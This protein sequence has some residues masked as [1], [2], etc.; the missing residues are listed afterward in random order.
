[1]RILI[2]G[3]TGFIGRYLLPLMNQHHIMLIGR[4]GNSPGG[5][6]LKFLK[7]DLAI[8]ASWVEQ[9]R[10]FSPE[11]CIHLAWSGLPDYS[12]AKCIENFNINME[13][14]GFLSDIKC[15]KI[16]VAGTCWEYG[17][18]QA[19]VSEKYLP[20]PTN[21]FAS[22]KTSIRL[23]GERL[24]V[25]KAVNLI[26]GRI[27]FVYGEGQRT[28]SLIPGCYQ[29][30]KNGKS[31]ELRNPNAVND[32]IH[33]SDVARAIL[34]LIESHSA[35]GIFNIGSGKPRRVIEV[36]RIIAKK[37]DLE[38]LLPEA[39]N[40]PQGNGLWADTSLINKTTGWYP[41]YSIEAGIDET[42]RS[43]ELKS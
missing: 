6:N 33:V 3:G 26:W 17:D 24:A 10:E 35:E 13:L 43:M 7:A 12:L 14:L 29:S 27:F 4:S 42:I 37:L 1:M 5:S 28:T 41:E 36:C 9:V 15:N 18:L 32:F 11:A 23:I 34:R 2:T 40:I 21:L 30:F 20:S 25:S 22:F 8:P 16:F 31:P 38:N 39:S 19:K